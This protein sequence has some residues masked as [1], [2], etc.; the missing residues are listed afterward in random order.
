MLETT[1]IYYEYEYKIQCVEC[2]ATKTFAKAPVTL[3][4]L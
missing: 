4:R 2:N 3:G 1:K